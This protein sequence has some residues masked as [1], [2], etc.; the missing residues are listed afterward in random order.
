MKKVTP[1]L[2]CALIASIAVA[3]A[4]KPVEKNSD[5]INLSEG[6][7]STDIFAIPLDESPKEERQ[8]MQEI[9]KKVEAKKAREA[10]LPKQARDAIKKANNK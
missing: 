6:P 3:C 1:I 7:D 8:D 2:L 4:P 9:Q 10:G 5:R